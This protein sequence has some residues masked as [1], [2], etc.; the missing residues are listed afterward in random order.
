MD[1]R[2]SKDYQTVSMSLE[3]KEECHSVVL[4][5]GSNVADRDNLVADAISWLEEVMTLARRSTIYSTEECHGK[6]CIYSNSVV[7][8][9]IKHT[10]EEFDNILKTYE[11]SCGRNE[12]ARRRGDVP[13]DIDIVIADG[14]VVRP[15][16]F[17]RQF[18][19]IGFDMLQKQL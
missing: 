3:G 17:S 9:E 7:C 5:L 11:Q 15:K 4:S 19:R 1:I 2:N 8:G 16:D 12:E 13:I 14:T 18:F 6:G 10:V